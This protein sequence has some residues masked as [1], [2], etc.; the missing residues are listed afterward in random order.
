[1]GNKKKVSKNNPPSFRIFMRKIWKNEA[2][3]NARAYSGDQLKRMSRGL[4]P[5][6]NGVSIHLHR[7]IGK[8]DLYKIVK[9]TRNQHI[10]FHKVCG[11]HL[12]SMWNMESIDFLFG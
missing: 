4:A 7:V 3:F 2:I 9:L 6:V 12:N 5:K 10:F 11:G 8:K 1:M